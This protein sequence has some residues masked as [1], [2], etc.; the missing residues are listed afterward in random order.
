[1]I[2]IVV[3]YPLMNY[4]KKMKKRNYKWVNENSK[5]FLN[6]KAGY[7]LEGET[8][9]ERFNTIALEIENELNVTGFAEEFLDLL[10]DKF[11]ALSTPFIS[12]VGRKGAL[13][14]SCSNQQIGDSMG[15]IYFA[16]GES[17]MMTKVGM[18]CSGKM[19]LRGAGD[20]ITD[21]ITPS[22]GSLYFAQGFDQVLQEVNQGVRRGFM[23]LYWDVEHSDIMEVLEIQRDGNPIQDLN[24][25]VCITRDFMKRAQANE[26][27]EVK[28]RNKDGKQLEE[29]LSAREILLKIHDS[30]LKTGLPYIFFTDNVN[31]A[32]SDV[33]KKFDLSIEASNLCTE[34]LEVSDDDYSFVCDIAAMN[35]EM[36]DDPRFGRAIEM[37]TYALDAL[38]NIFQRKL[39]A[40]RDS[41]SKEDRLKFLFLQKAYLSSLHFRDI[42]VGCTGY[43]TLLQNRMIPFESMEAKYLN[44]KLFKKIQ[45]HTLIASKDLAEVYGEPEKLKGFGRRNNLL[46]AV[47]PN[48]SSAFIL[49]Q[50]SQGI[51]P[52]MSNCY[53]K[54]IA[55]TKHLVKNPVLKKLL[56]ER[57][58]DNKK[59]WR[60]ISEADGS[61]KDLECL[62][63]HEKKV[64]KTFQEI[65][66][67]EII[68]QAAARQKFIDQGQS[69]NLIINQK[70]SIK[71]LNALLYEA[72]RLGIKT[73]YYQHG[74]NSAQQLRKSLLE[75]EHC[76]G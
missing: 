48:T 29:F 18:G 76:A 6:N 7:L 75:C 40:W 34:I 21:S 64:F 24:Y 60:Q 38:H 12:N 15:E 50:I 74:V 55:K 51:E 26:L 10:E 8:V 56:A 61:V 22:P 35:A 17:A 53:I 54:D 33:Y 47:A 69:L 49:G 20:T 32:K 41:D 4:F 65:A 63:D 72:E 11:Y 57:G 39:E 1:M 62:T 46:N 45:E 43:H 66:P 19:K 59:V 5:L 67:I 68:Q 31:E 28:K 73:L 25:G 16:K 44:T 27:S 70:T 9:E 23:A 58:Q 71:D 36:I 37:L 2:N 14:F 52:L 42:G 3:L 13:P 30:R